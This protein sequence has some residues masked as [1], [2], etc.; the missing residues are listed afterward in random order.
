MNLLHIQPQSY[1]A[2]CSSIT[3]TL[4]N[5]EGAWNFTVKCKASAVV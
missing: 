3:S 4:A 2:K 1:S 5:I